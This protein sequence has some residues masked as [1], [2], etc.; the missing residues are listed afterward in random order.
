MSKWKAD[1]IKG[2]QELR[3]FLSRDLGP[4]HAADVA[5]SSFERAWVYAQQGHEIRA[6]RALLFGIAHHIQVD[7]GRRRKRSP[8]ESIDDAWEDA[9]PELRSEL[10]PEEIAGDRQ[11]VDMLSKAIDALPPRCREAF[12]LHN[13]HG[14]SHAEVADQMGISVS[15]VEKHVANAL[16][17]CRTIL[18]R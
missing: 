16:R 13:I 10:T 12:I 14:L 2:Y 17:F 4:D 6:P 5:Q 9:H 15:A 1:L 8:H 7:Q 11:T 3:R 18:E